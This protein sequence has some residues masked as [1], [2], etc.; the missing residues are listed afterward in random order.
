MRARQTNYGLIDITD[1]I[2]NQS[3]IVLMH[4]IH[5]MTNVIVTWNEQFDQ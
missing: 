5:V 4:F 3:I 1:S 2:H